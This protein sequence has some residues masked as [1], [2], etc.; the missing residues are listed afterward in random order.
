M[1]TS[2]T[3]HFRLLDLPKEL[4]L[5]IYEFL[6]IT[7][8]RHSIVLPDEKEVILIIK[9]L[10]V[11]LL[12]TGRFVSEEAR[13]FMEEK[14]RYMKNTP[15]RIICKTVRSR[16]EETFT[17]SLWSE[18][19]ARVEAIEYGSHLMPDLDAKSLYHRLKSKGA[20]VNGAWAAD[21]EYVDLD[22]LAR[23][24]QHAGWHLQS[25]T[26]R[27]RLELG[28]RL[29]EIGRYELSN[30]D[31][32]MQLVILYRWVRRLHCKVFKHIFCGNAS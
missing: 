6:P 18:T 10:P 20:C 28:L 9:S 3:T 13:P 15:P 29:E 14:L 4:R 22:S 12:S 26:S 7:T 16:M 27:R 32:A 24:I 8:R 5:M 2:T 25:N 30:E 19:W 17:D 21:L 11:C 1:A 23:F 31:I